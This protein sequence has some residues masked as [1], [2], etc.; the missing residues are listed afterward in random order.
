M[1]YA[2][3]CWDETPGRGGRTH[4]ALGRHAATEGTDI[5]QRKTFCPEPSCHYVSIDLG[6]W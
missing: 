1:S 5:L 2:V 4:L 3:R 6:Q